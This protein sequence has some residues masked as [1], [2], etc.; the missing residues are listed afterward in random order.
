MPVGDTAMS[1]QSRIGSQSVVG[2]AE[3]KPELS[4]SESQNASVQPRNLWAFLALAG[5]ECT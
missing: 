3:A 1:W 2:K 4:A 5:E